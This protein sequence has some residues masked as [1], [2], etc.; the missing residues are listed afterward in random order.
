MGDA[1][2]GGALTKL[3]RLYLNKNRVGDVGLVAFVDA[4]GGMRDGGSQ[5]LP[6]LYELWLSNNRLSDVGA[7]RLFT[8]LGHGAMPGIGDLRLQYNLLGDGT[9]A[10]LVGT[11]GSDAFA[12]LWYLGLSDNSF[13]RRRLWPSTKGSPRV[14]CSGS[15]S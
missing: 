3:T 1:I 7:T 15:S 8:A 11:M 4:L 10:S 14:G 6:C 12:K 9:I 13:A 2:A 5:A